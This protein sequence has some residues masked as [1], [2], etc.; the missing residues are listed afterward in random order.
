MKPPVL[1]VLAILL[2]P[3]PGR[4]AVLGTATLSTGTSLVG[5]E[6]RVR[7]T[8]GYDLGDFATQKLLFDE[9][10]IDSSSVGSVLVAT[11]DSDTDFSAVAARLT[12]STPD[13]LCIGTCEE[14][15]CG[16]T[17]G[18][19]SLFFHL[20]TSDFAPATIQKVSLRVDALSF[21]MDGQGDPI[22]LYT[23]AITVEG[24]KGVVPTLPVSWG[25]LKSRYR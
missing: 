18:P 7:P 4:G 20:P 2:L 22:V 8:F 13:Y 16:A 19:E 1:A 15:T 17:C 14:I 10:W 3:A 24:V 9:V 23:F 12:N 21:G 11:V 5:A 6:H 25:K